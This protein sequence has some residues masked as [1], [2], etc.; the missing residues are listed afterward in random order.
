M[1]V[2]GAASA[3]FLE[4]PTLVCQA[5]WKRVT[6]CK[7][8]VGSSPAPSAGY[9]KPV[10]SAEEGQ[11]ITMFAILAVIA[12]GLDY[13]LIGLRATTNSWFSPVALLA[14]AVVFLAL[15]ALGAWERMKNL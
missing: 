13:V 6:S 8:V 2:S 7:G 4:G 12:A 11:V 1:V 3:T 14:L 15:H 5:R 9:S 10:S